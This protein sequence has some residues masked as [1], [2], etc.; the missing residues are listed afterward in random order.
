[1]LAFF[2]E[3]DREIVCFF[4]VAET[5]L[6]IWFLSDECTTAFVELFNFLMV[7]EATRLVT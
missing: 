7:S 5:L 6:G 1:M 4:I 2:S 3:K